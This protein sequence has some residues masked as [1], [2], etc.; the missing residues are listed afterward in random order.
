ME[1][2]PFCFDI[3]STKLCAEDPESRSATGYSG[4]PSR[5]LCDYEG[6]CEGDDGLIVNLNQWGI[7]ESVIS[8]VSSQSS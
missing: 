1:V 4:P 6:S 3:L 8:L 7:R 5:F 2:A